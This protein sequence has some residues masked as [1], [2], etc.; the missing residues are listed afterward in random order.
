MKTLRERFEEK[1]IP[2]LLMNNLLTIARWIV[3]PFPLYAFI[4]V[5]TWV[6]GWIFLATVIVVVGWAAVAAWLTAK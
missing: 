6:C 5:G 4:A 1:F 2:E 3:L